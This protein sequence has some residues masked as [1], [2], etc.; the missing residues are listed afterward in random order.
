MFEVERAAETLRPI[1]RRWS[2]LLLVTAVFGMLA[3]D[4]I[5]KALAQ[6]DVG[7]A[8]LFETSQS[9]TSSIL[10]PPAPSVADDTI[11][12]L[13]Q[14][15]AEVE[16]RLEQRDATDFRSAELAKQKFSVRPFGRAHIDM[17][18]FDQDD[19]NKATIGNANN[20]VDIRRL[21][22]GVEGEGFDFFRYRLDVDFVTPDSTPDSRPTVFDAYLDTQNLPVIGN[23]RA[24]HFREP[25]SLE[26]LDSSHD[27]PFLERSTAINALAPFRNIGLMAFDW[28]EDE[29]ATWSYGIFHENT[30]EFGEH[31]AD[32]TG[33][34]ATGRATWL[35]W[36]NNDNSRLWHLG[37]SYSY[38][39]LGRTER[40]FDQT[41]EIVLKEGA[42]ITPSFVDTGDGAALINIS[43]YHLASFETC[44]VLGPFS[45]QGEYVFLSGNQQSGES[46]FL[47]GGYVEAMY[48]LTGENRN[49]LRKQGIFGAVTPKSSFLG[50]DENGETRCG[51]G[52]WE[53][54]A[55]ASHLDLDHRSVR[56]G[57]LTN[58][59]FGLNW[60]YA[61][62]SRV[63]FNYIH[64][65]L[66]RDSIQSNADIFAVRF[67][68]A[69]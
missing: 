58:I 42:T 67:Q 19:A 37:A 59:T 30:N 38:R 40:Q 9:E 32:R 1:R 39:R 8:V 21:R 69:F 7:G 10:N 62:R 28:N 47:H 54:A 57:K 27:F 23:L 13:T 29:T 68:Y 48:W 61:V 18:F 16:G 52:A 5:S 49:Y 53:V 64:A 22:L 55:R 35:P 26:M 45:A 34:A 20:G 63:M 33:I 51:W 31:N 65:F 14:R 25:F 46:L 56:G 11:A 17:G 36:I 12:Q 6:T 44:T 60:Y 3:V 24:G 2:A 4:G 15:L 41:P 50:R 43:N 66:D